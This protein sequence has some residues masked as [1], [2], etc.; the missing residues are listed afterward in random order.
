MSSRNLLL[1][2]EQRTIAPLL[3]RVLRE[4]AAALANGGLAAPHLDL[5]VER[6]MNSGFRLVDYVE[7]R[8]AETLAPLATAGHRPGRLLAAAHLGSVRL[9]DNVPVAV[10]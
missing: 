5:A 1:T 3:N 6:L 2:P 9:I 7:L 8:D 4:T 10:G